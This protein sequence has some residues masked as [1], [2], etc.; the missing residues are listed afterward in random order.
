[1]S[2]EVLLAQAWTRRQR[3]R[4]LLVVLAVALAIS[5]VVFTTAAYRAMAQRSGTLA[6]DL[7]GSWD[8]VIVP[9]IALR[10]TLGDD[11]IADLAADPAVKDLVR[12]R[13]IHADI[14]DAADTTYYDSWPAACIATVDGRAPAELGDGRWP[15]D[16]AEVIE[17]V[18]SGGLASRWRVATG[19]TMPIHAP[20][21]TFTL[22]LV[23][24]TAERISHRH[25]SGLFVSPATL[26]RLAGE[27][28]TAT[29]LY[30]DVEGESPMAVAQR[31]RQ[32]LDAADPPAEAKDLTDFA[33]ELGLDNTLTRIRS[34]S[35]AASALVLIAAL[36]IV[37]TAM[38]AGADE[39][40]RQLTL[41]R[42]I[43]ATRSQVLRT[44]LI[45]AILLA[46]SASVIGV[47]LGVAWL[48]LLSLARSDFFGGVVLPDP[49]S[50]SLALG[51]AVLGVVV[52]ALLP[53]WRASRVSPLAA[54]R[55]APPG[56]AAFPWI[57]TA[58]AVVLAAAAISAN[59]ITAAR[60]ALDPRT[61]TG[62]GL[63]ALALAALLGARGLAHLAVPLVGRPL[64]RGFGLP[65]GLLRLHQASAQRRATGV[66]LTLGVCL[67]FSVLMNV[68]GRSMVI[69]FL[70]SP[71]LP[72]QIVSL[73]P[74]GVPPESRDEVRTLAGVVADRV[75]PLRVEQTFLGTELIARSGGDVDAMSIQVLGLDPAVLVGDEGDD[76]LLPVESAIASEDLAH[77][78]GQDLTC[79]IPPSLARRFDLTEG[80][81]LAVVAGGG[82]GEIRLRI[83]G[84][85]SLPGWQWVTK[86]GRMRTLTDKPMA[87]I[88]VSD[89]T[90]EALGI[91]RVRHWLVDTAPDVDVARLR[92]DLQTIAD[93]HAGA[94]Q[95]AHY[96]Q[97]R[98]DKPSVKLIATGEIARRM[99]TRSD[100]VIWV[101]GAIPLATLLIAMLGVANGVAA[102]IRARQWDFAVLRSVGMAG[103]QAK[104][105]VLIEVASCALAAGILSTAIGIAAAWIAIDLS[106]QLFDTGTG[107]PP[108]IIPWL[109]LAIA[110]AVTVGAALLAAWI[111]AKRLARRTPVS[112]LHEGRAGG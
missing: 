36:F 90:A 96:G 82:D 46:V 101:L 50:L 37:A 104:A 62:L 43:G 86:M 27:M 74:A 54:I 72:D 56:R 88:L 15:G 10:P 99:Q 1:M 25:A 110:W 12:T 32:R 57:R 7:L 21:G 6:Q 63:V 40:Q 91:P 76:A 47:P 60:E 24:I 98:V 17:G 68:W 109:D 84:I 58:I 67:G 95:S 38:G 111:P 35:A 70:P 30:V 71:R 112:L 49:L 2:A 85:A 19:D 75:V 33:A 78:L 4:S 39:R 29:R 81:D 59:A 53:A 13:V 26:D 11:L 92:R 97:A 61:A 41:L 107:A 52:A 5:L 28:T 69:P 66:I 64:A 31:W 65:D 80:G 3:Q 89:A 20:G 23:G 103:G 44:V 87:A 55:I 45:E 100:A 108:L 83:A 9:R 14:E 79:L 22:R 34:M 77:R 93:T 16:D 105:L 73:M 48:A 18:L 106:L 8:L 102:G 94:Y 51:I 42:S